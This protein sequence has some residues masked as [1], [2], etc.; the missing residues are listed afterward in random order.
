MVKEG[1]PV[2]NERERLAME[3]FLKTFE[4]GRRELRYSFLADDIVATHWRWRD[5]ELVGK[6]AVREQYLG[7]LAESFP[8]LHFKVLDA[9]FGEDKLV[10]RGEFNATFARDWI[11]IPAHGGRVRWNAHDIYQFKGGKIVRFWYGNDTLTVAR[12][13][14]ALPDDGKPW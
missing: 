2:T 13:L 12:Q 1:G 7:P 10:I 6:K 8:S 5:R 3:E 9:I 4:P 11:R 14:G